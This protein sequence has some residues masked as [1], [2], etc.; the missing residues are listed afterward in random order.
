MN[1]LCP[2]CGKQF[3][4]RKEKI[5]CSRKCYVEDMKMTTWADEEYKSKC[6]ERVSGK[7]N[8]MYGTHRYGKDNPFY[9]KKHS[10]ETKKKIS[11]DHKVNSKFYSNRVKGSSN[12]MWGKGL[13][14]NANGMYGK[15]H[16]EKTKK[17]ISYRMSGINNP[18]YGKPSPQGSGNGWSGWYKD[19]YFRSILE[20]SAMIHFENNNIIYELAEKMRIKYSFVNSERTYAPDFYLP[21]NDIVVECKYSKLINSPNNIAKFNSARLKFKRF[22]VLTEKDI[23]ILNDDKILELYLTQNIIWNKKYKKLFKD[24]IAKNFRLS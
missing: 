18:M 4:G 5:R 13:F 19:Q 3:R 7:N 11:D 16:S 20:L 22:E 10:E 24:R 15:H 17:R 12:P 8:P 2:I 6:R 23:P 1:K 9:G 21:E 14:G